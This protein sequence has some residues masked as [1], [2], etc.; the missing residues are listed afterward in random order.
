[1]D[2]EA[3]ISRKKELLSKIIVSKTAPEKLNWGF[4][5]QESPSQKEN[6]YSVKI[7]TWTDLLFASSDINPTVEPTSFN[8]HPYGFIVHDELG[9]AVLNKAFKKILMSL[10][11]QSD[12]DEDEIKDAIH[13]YILNNNLETKGFYYLIKKLKNLQLEDLPDLQA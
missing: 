5:T 11:L 3:W 7:D 8:I 12:F 13:S 2:K 9:Q 10:N 4:L 1:M 6:K